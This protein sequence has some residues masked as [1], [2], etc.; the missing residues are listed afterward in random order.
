MDVQ[1]SVNTFF[2]YVKNDVQMVHVEVAP[3]GWWRNGWINDK[4]LA[5]ALELVL[6]KFNSHTEVFYYRV[7]GLNTHGKPEYTFFVN[8]GA[9]DFKLPFD[10]V[11]DVDALTYWYRAQNC[12]PDQYSSFA[13]ERMNMGQAFGV[14]AEMGL[15]DFNCPIVRLA[16][17][18]GIEIKRMKADPDF[19]YPHMLEH[20]EKRYHDD[21]T[22]TSERM[23]H[24]R[25][26]HDHEPHDSNAADELSN[27]LNQHIERARGMIR[28]RGGEFLERMGL[29]TSL[30]DN[31]PDSHIAEEYARLQLT[32]IIRA[33]NMHREAGQGF[34]ERNGIP[35]KFYDYDHTTATISGGE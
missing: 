24:A 32:H 25:I 14:F 29:P 34:L 7:P 35:A 19:V 21:T 11:K 1:V 28:F 6:T 31:P 5:E 10:P 33:Q 2:F 9:H 20:R 13:S 23:V 18:R 12:Y 8:V 30:L 27:L 4:T 15:P 3:G 22:D 16:D 26:A 17:T